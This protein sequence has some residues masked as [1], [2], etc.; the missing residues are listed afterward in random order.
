MPGRG[1]RGPWVKEAKEGKIIKSEAGN[2][3]ILHSCMVVIQCTLCGHN[4]KLAEKTGGWILL[5]CRGAVRWVSRASSSFGGREIV[6]VNGV[7]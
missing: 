1:G 7:Q 6:A 2:P 4:G 3:Q 5:E